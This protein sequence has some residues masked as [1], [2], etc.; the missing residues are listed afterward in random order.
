[1][2]IYVKLSHYLEKKTQNKYTNGFPYNCVDVDRTVFIK[3]KKYIQNMNLLGTINS[4][5]CC[6]IFLLL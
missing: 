3:E 2:A 4:L 6:F 5:G 1:M